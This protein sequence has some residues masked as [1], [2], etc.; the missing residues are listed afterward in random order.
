M[1]KTHKMKY[2]FKR[3]FA[4]TVILVFVITSGCMHSVAQ[5]NAMEIAPNAKV[6]ANDTFASITFF[7]NVNVGDWFSVPVASFNKESNEIEGVAILDN[8]QKVTLLVKPG[9]H[10]FILGGESG[11]YLVADVEANK[12]Y[13]YKIEP[14]LGVL[15]PNFMAK[16]MSLDDLNLTV[17]KNMITA[18]K[19]V[20]LA[21]NGKAWF[22]ANKEMLN[23][24]FKYLKDSFD[25]ND[26]NL[27]K[28]IL[29]AGFGLDSSL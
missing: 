6:Q 13:Y 9:H 19:S 14:C 1:Y 26:A 3:L 17:I 8:A 15:K 5:D 18:S 28:G 25:A 22:D 10:E 2:I 29:Q 4:L 20:V 12:N 23:Y 27:K 16:A 24:K 7:R 11:A 21:K